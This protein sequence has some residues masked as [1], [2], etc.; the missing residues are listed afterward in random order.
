MERSIGEKIDD[1]KLD[2]NDKQGLHVIHW[3]IDQTTINNYLNMK[4]IGGVREN[5]G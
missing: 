2:K 4:K 5:V 3:L 1:L